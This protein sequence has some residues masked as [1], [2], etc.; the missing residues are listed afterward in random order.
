MV[1]IS[2]PIVKRY[3]GSHPLIPVR[4]VHLETLALGTPTLGLLDTGSDR[5]LFHRFYG[6]ELGIDFDDIEP[7]EGVG[8]GGGF[9]VYYC[10]V[11]VQV[12]EWMFETLVGFTDAPSLDYNLLGR[13]GFFDRIQFGIRE[14]M[15]EVYLRFQP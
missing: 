14:S 6:E 3:I 10:R 7:Q 8:V 1:T 9:L 15:R 4:L 11:G 12:E 2:Y 13:Q 5:N